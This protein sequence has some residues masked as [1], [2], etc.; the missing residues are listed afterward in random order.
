MLLVAR[1]IFLPD[2]LAVVHFRW[3]DTAVRR[4]RVELGRLTWLVII[5]ELVVR[6]AENLNPAQAG[7]LIARLGFVVYCA[8]L[9]WFFYRVLGPSKGVLEQRR[10]EPG[11]GILLRSYP[12]WFALL[13]IVPLVLACL[14]LAGYLYTADNI[15][16]VFQRTLWMLAGLIVVH[17]LAVRL[18]RVTQHRLAY[19]AAVER[20]LAAF[21]ALREESGDE[22]G[23]LHVEEPEID[24]DALSDD[25]RQLLDIVT[26]FAG[27]IGVVSLWSPLLPA[28][29]ILDDVTL[30]YYTTGAPGALERIPVT[31]KDLALALVYAIGVGV[32]AKRLPAVLE[33]LLLQRSGMSAADRYTVVTLSSYVLVAIGFVLVLGTLGVGW[34]QVQWL[35]AALGVGIGFGLQEIVANFIS[36]LIILFERPILVGDVVTVGDNSGVVTR[37]QIR[38]TT[39]RDWERKE[40]LV[41]NKEFITGRL[42]NWSLSD[43]VTRVVVVAG[44]DYGADAD[45]ALALMKEAAAEQVHVLGDPAPI[46]TFEG[47]GDNALTLMLRAYVDTID[48]RLST[49][50]DLHKS[51]GR[52]FDEAGIAIAFPQRDLHLD[53][54]E[55]LRVS[56]ESALPPLP[57][58]GD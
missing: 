4:M 5:S 21:A 8:A 29:Q 43:E 23:S 32:L 39:I 22:A 18:L 12:L 1:A 27:V 52:K 15:Y 45:K 57:E 55:P 40:L 11:A 48:H 58:S 24:L 19:D 36:G 38:A 31:L 10:R 41:P 30:W 14:G 20:R 51:I 25:S 56:I 13:L 7:G 54:R 3:P 46:V 6:L 26:V 47:F 9:A 16:L 49:I 33:M 53:A 35:V 2:G 44:V 37:I 34:S 28:L 50:T 17:A 42:L